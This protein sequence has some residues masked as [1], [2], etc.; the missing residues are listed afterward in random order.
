MIIWR[1]WGILAFFA[2][3]ISVGFTALLA[4]LSGTDMAGVTWQG[5]PAF[6]IVGIAIFFLG[7]HVNVTGPTQRF[8]TSRAMNRGFLAP[9]LDGSSAP[10][11]LSEQPPLDQTEQAQLRRM[12]NRHSLFFIPMQWW[13]FILP[14]LGVAITVASVN[15]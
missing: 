4:A 9:T 10:L 15:N 14:L 3:G 11:P 1:G 6:L 5:V 12:R 13:G 8:A 7:Q 2:I